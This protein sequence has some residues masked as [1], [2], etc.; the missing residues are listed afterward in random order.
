MPRGI[1]GG[2]LVCQTPK[3]KKA[4]GL[5]R[6]RKWHVCGIHHKCQHDVC[7]ERY[8][9][10]L[11]AVEGKVWEYI[12][13]DLRHLQEDKTLHV[14]IYEELAKACGGKADKKKN[15]Q[16]RRLD[17]DSRIAKFTTHL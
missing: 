3:S 6:I 4:D 13:Q 8:S 1:R 2:S 10:S 7:P 16:S 15:L 14:Y 11:K 17:L 12:K 5:I 9:V